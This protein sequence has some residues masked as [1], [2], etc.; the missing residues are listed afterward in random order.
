VTITSPRTAPLESVLEAN[1][2]ALAAPICP[3]AV[4]TSKNT[5]DGKKRRVDSEVVT[6]WFPSG[7]KHLLLATS[8]IC[9]RGFSVLIDTL[10]LA[11]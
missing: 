10:G 9:R 8:P 4:A 6:Y 2:A 5:I 11:R 7:V 3:I 1:A